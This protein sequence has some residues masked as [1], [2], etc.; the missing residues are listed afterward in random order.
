SS[1]IPA[2]SWGSLSWG[3]WDRSTTVAAPARSLACALRRLRFSRSAADRRRRRTAFC[4]DLPLSLM[5]RD[6]DR[7][8]REE[9]SRRGARAC[10]LFGL[11]ARI[12]R[13]RGRHDRH[14]RPAGALP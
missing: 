13:L 14:A 9:R 2:E 7:R 1:P 10:P 5:A 8:R 12:A 4:T 6:Y 11:V 3:F